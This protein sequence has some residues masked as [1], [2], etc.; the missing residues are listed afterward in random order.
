MKRAK[1]F[2]AETNSEK[3]VLADFATTDPLFSSLRSNHVIIAL[4]TSGEMEVEINYVVYK[5]KKNSVL[6]LKPLDIVTF[7]GKSDDF[8]GKVLLLTNN[9][10]SPMFANLNANIFKK[11]QVLPIVSYDSSYLDMIAQ[12]FAMLEQAQAI[13]DYDSFEE[14]T[15]KMVAA[16]FVL[17]ES[18]VK[19]VLGDKVSMPGVV[20]RKR[21]LFRKFVEAIIESYME[22][23]EVLFYANVLGVSSGYLNEVCNE[24]SGHSAKEIIDQAVSSRLKAELSYTSK[25]IQELADEYNFPSQSYFSRYYKR[26]TGMTPSEFRKE[27]LKE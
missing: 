6:I 14:Y 8:N 23:R 4:C 20:M 25:T 17:Q 19:N 26:M 7:I 2:L 1:E 11:M 15:A 13:L 22:A 3:I 10:I 5:F 18:Y 16:M 27:R 21:E 12:F 24:V 9:V